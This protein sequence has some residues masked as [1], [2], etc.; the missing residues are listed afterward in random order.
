ML[1]AAVHES[2][3][4]TIVKYRNVC[5]RAAAKAIADVTQ[6]SFEDRC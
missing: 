3:C 2:A 1:F 5:F 4:G 6:T